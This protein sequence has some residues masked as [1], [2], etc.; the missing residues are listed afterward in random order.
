[1][2]MCVTPFVLGRTDLAKGQW[3]QCGDRDYEARSAKDPHDF[4]KLVVPASSVNSTFISIPITESDS[5][6][7]DSNLF[8]SPSLSK[9]LA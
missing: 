8:G 4:L 7:S 6:R 3:R 1:V 2:P 5:Y 9:A